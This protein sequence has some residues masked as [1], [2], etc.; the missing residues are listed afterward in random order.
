MGISK[1]PRARV[2]G[3]EPRDTAQGAHEVEESTSTEVY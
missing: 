3:L 1:R 2:G